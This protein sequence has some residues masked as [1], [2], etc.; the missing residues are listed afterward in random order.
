MPGYDSAGLPKWL[1]DKE[2]ACNAGATGDASSIPGSGRSPGGGHGNP[3]QYS[4]LENRMDRGNWWATIH[5]VTKSWT[6]PKRLSMHACM[7]SA[8]TRRQGTV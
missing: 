3:L 5:R 1:S 4:C 7:A 2:S 8:M 6:R